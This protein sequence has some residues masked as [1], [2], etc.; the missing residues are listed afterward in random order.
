MIGKILS[1]TLKVA[2]IPI[3]AASIALDL[4]IGDDGSKQSRT[5]N[6]GTGDLETLRDRIAEALEEIDQ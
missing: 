4:A 6:P 1:T 2:T 3:D 5:Q